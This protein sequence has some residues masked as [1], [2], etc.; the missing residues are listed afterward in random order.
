M[1]P[2]QIWADVNGDNQFLDHQQG[3]PQAQ[4]QWKAT[5]VRPRPL[6]PK[7]PPPRS[8]QGCRACCE[9]AVKAAKPAA[10]GC[11]G[12]EARRREGR[13]G[14]SPEKPVETAKRQTEETVK[15][16]KPV[17]EKA[18]RLLSLSLK[19]VEAAKPVVEKAVE[20][21]KTAAAKTNTR[22]DQQGQAPQVIC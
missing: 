2:C 12:C 1:A 18:V 3:Y 20:A 10:E 5:A 6:P 15:A 14:L 7:R 16:A 17:V 21:V 9:K 11:Q 22:K 19:A 4:D 13:Q 8:S